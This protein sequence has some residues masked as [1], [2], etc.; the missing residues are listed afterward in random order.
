MKQALD[1]WTGIYT[2]EKGNMEE[3]VLSNGNLQELS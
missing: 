1:L 3:E 2:E